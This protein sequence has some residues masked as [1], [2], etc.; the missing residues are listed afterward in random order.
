MKHAFELVFVW[1]GLGTRRA[2]GDVAR[3]AEWL[4]DH[5]PTDFRGTETHL[6]AMQMCLLALEGEALNSDARFVFVKAAREAGIL[7]L[8]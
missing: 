3:A 2:I 6:A 7:A 5:W 4:T 8:D 1:E